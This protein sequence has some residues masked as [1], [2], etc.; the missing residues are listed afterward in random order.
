MLKPVVSVLSTFL[1][2]YCFVSVSCCLDVSGYFWNRLIADRGFRFFFAAFLSDWGSL[3]LLF[4]NM[5]QK[6]EIGEIGKIKAFRLVW[7]AGA[8]R[9]CDQLSEVSFPFHPPPCPEPSRQ[10]VGD[11]LT[12]RYFFTYR[13]DFT[14][15]HV[16]VAVG[17]VTRY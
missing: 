9:F 3:S 11:K 12:R 2:L 15:F 14:S 17:V 8:D 16:A 6:P 5:S 13:C 1:C 7:Y 4:K 10:N